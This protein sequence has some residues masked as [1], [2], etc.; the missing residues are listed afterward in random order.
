MRVHPAARVPRLSARDGV[1]EVYVRSRALEGRAT[2]EARATIAAALGVATSKVTCVHGERSR[3][4]L[5]AANG[6]DVRQR[7]AD[8]L[9]D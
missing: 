4:K 1:I 6:E 3:T 5:F 9:G 7:L 8:L 2:E